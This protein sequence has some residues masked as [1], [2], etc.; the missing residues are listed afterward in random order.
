MEEIFKPSYIELLE[1]GKLEKR[2]YELKELYEKCEVCPRKCGVNRLK[3]EKGVCKT[4][5]NAMVA[6]YCL[7]RGEEPPISGKRGSG[8]IFFANCNL[9]CIYCQNYEISQEWVEDKGTISAEHLSEIYLFLQKSGAHNINWVSPSHIVP[10]AVEALYYAA[11]KGLKIPIVYNSNGYD[12]LKTLRL[13]DGIV[14][15]Y[16]PDLKYFD[17]KIAFELSNVKNYTLYAKEAIKEM[18]NQVG[19]LILDEDGVALRGLL[20]RHLVLPNG[21]SQTKEV[22]KFLALEVSLDVS[23]SLMSQYYPTHL[24][25][26]DKRIARPITAKEYKECVDYLYSLGLEEGYIQELSS[27]LHYRPNFKKDGHPFEQ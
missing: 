20:V 3:N 2:V 1:S 21:L 27:F 13:L 10:S 7:H 17:D 23:V 6:S 18:W 25:Y 16:M 5:L 9:A 8:T 24:A 19:K 4:G 15:I 14:D 26:V 11:K 12:S 22:L